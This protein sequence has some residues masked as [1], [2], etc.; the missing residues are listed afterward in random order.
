MDDLADAA[1]HLVE[2]YESEEHINVG[3]GRDIAVGELAKLIREVTGFAGA[4]TYDH[5]KRDG[6]PRKRLD[7]S[8]L[9]SLGWQ[10]KS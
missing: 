10:A 1:V 9:E 4:L 2:V 7:V 5:S 8:R 3:A 6:A